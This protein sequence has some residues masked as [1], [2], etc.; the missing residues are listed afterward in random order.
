MRGSKRQMNY[1]TS[2]SEL[3]QRCSVADIISFRGIE[4]ITIFQSSFV[5]NGLT[6]TCVLITT[7][8]DTVVPMKYTFT[9]LPIQVV[10]HLMES[11]LLSLVHS[12]AR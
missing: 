5:I 11:S 12:L 7:N 8:T 10:M 9:S 3:E 1:L 6:Y 4:C 2:Q